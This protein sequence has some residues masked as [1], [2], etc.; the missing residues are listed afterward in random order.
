MN[1]GP[2]R[3]NDQIRLGGGCCA[4]Y[5]D[6]RIFP[7][8]ALEGEQLAGSN[9]PQG[10]DYQIETLILHSSEGM[11]T[12]VDGGGPHEPETREHCVHGDLWTSGVVGDQSS[13]LHRE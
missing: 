6:A 9:V 8:F 11:L 7:Y 13:A 3:A 12:I 1:T 10:Q 4:D 5:R 2:H